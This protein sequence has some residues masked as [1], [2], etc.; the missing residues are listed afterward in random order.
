MAVTRGIVLHSS[1]IC[2]EYYPATQIV[3]LAESPETTH[4]IAGLL[5]QVFHEEVVKAALKDLLVA[6]TC[7]S[8]CAVSF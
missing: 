1:H 3:D 2:A 7:A 4:A 5:K 6:P 8:F